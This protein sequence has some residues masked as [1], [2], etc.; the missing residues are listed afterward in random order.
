MNNDVDRRRR[1]REDIL[2]YLSERPG[3]HLTKKPD[4]GAL[5]RLII[6]Y[7][8]WL[9]LTPLVQYVMLSPLVEWL[10][11][12]GTVPPP[13]EINPIG[14]TWGA[15]AATTFF[16]LLWAVGVAEKGKDEMVE[17]RFC[18]MGCYLCVLWVFV[19]VLILIELYIS[20]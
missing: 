16:F 2:K 20:S 6:I 15:L 14:R 17:F 10:P 4:Y 7:S 11:N 8:V 12:I 5:V 18:E 9:M 1:R 19:D 3:Q 13:D